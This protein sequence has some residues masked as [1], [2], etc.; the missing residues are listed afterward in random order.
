[1]STHRILHHSFV[2]FDTYESKIQ[3]IQ[4]CLTL[5]GTMKITQ[6]GCLLIF[7]L[8]AVGCATTYPVIGQV[9]GKPRFTGAISKDFLT[10]ASGITIHSLDGKVVCYGTLYTVYTPNVSMS[11]ENKGSATLHCSDSS[12][13]LSSWR[14]SRCGAGY[15]NGYTDN[16]NI[17][18]FTFGRKICRP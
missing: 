2:L 6:I 18:T 14:N 12:T 5:R 16:G 7:S 8:L 15:G 11:C 1:M 10:G 13:I 17:I 3:R 9:N 4:G